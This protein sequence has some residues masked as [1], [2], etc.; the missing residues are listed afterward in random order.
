MSK[1][2]RVWKHLEPALSPSAC[3]SMTVPWYCSFKRTNVSLA[4]SHALAKAAAG[5]RAKV[6]KE[7]EEWD[8]NECSARSVRGLEWSE[9]NWICY[10]AISSKLMHNHTVQ[11]SLEGRGL[12]GS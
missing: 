1:D 6:L 2:K 9:Q 12:S 10:P 3:K 4:A 5:V 11:L 7:G 8:A